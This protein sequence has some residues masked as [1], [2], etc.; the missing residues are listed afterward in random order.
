MNWKFGVSGNEGNVTKMSVIS[1]LVK[2]S[3]EALV[4]S[5]TKKS[6]SKL[7]LPNIVF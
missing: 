6:V 1:E 3:Q 2:S 5:I 7:V 4:V